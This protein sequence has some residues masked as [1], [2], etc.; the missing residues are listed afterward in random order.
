MN[1][2][3]DFCDRI[4]LVFGWREGEATFHKVIS[5]LRVYGEV[6]CLCC[7]ASVFCSLLGNLQREGLL[8][9]EA[10]FR[11]FVLILCCWFVHID[12][13]IVAVGEVEAVSGVFRYRVVYSFDAVFCENFF[14]CRAKPKRGYALCLRVDGDELSADVCVC[15]VGEDVF[16]LFWGVFD[17]RVGEIWL[18]LSG[19]FAGYL[20]DIA[21]VVLLCDVGLVEPD[22]ANFFVF[23]AE[24]C[25][26]YHHPS[27]ASGAAHADLFYGA[28]KGYLFSFFQGAG[29]CLCRVGIAAGEVVEQVVYGLYTEFFE[30]GLLRFFDG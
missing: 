18:F 25:F 12:E 30:G 13:R 5:F 19:D 28:D 3:E 1:I 15:I 16:R 7:E 24:G 2:F 21:L 6:V 4:L 10:F 8:K 9:G 11:G 17:D 29:E 27:F 23:G 26:C 14:Y 22:G 20:Y